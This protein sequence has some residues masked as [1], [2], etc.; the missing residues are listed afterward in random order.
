MGNCNFTVSD[1][2]LVSLLVQFGQILSVLDQFLVQ[3]G[4]SY[5]FQTKICPNWTESW[6]ETGKL[7]FP[8]SSFSA[9]S[10]RRPKIFFESIC[11]N[12]HEFELV[13]YYSLH[14]TRCRYDIVFNIEIDIHI[15]FCLSSKFTRSRLN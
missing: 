8:I 14:Q 4:Q 12:S 2:L 3:Y 11:M 7:H 13:Q 10:C 6:S 9:F 5:L 15:K 1:K